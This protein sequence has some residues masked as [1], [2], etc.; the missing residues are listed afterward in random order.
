MPSSV[1]S[2]I[3]NG[4]DNIQLVILEVL[5]TPQLFLWYLKLLVFEVM[6]LAADFSLTETDGSWG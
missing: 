3:N 1:W 4:T 5:S 6:H 2:D